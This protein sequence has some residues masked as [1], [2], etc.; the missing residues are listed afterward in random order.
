MVKSVI[1]VFIMLQDDANEGHVF[2]AYVNITALEVRAPNRQ[3]IHLT[4]LDLHRLGSLCALRLARYGTGRTG[5]VRCSLY[6]LQCAR[7]S[8]GLVFER[9][10][11]MP[12]HLIFFSQMSPQKTTKSVS[13]DTRLMSLDLHPVS[14]HALSR[15]KSRVQW[16]DFHQV[17]ITHMK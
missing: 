4:L 17:Y 2:A 14:M 16:L 10:V 12:E 1:C 8:I 13:C 11:V 3:S 7:K 9:H 6:F 5:R 15:P